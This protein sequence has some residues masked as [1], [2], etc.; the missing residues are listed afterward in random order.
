MISMT[1]MLLTPQYV[2]AQGAPQREASP[3]QNPQK[4]KL[5]LA[6]HMRGLEMLY[7]NNTISTRENFC[8][9]T[10]DSALNNLTIRELSTLATGKGEPVDDKKMKIKVQ[11][12]C[13]HYIIKENEYERCYT[14]PRFVTMMRTEQG[15]R[16]MCTC[17]GDKISVFVKD[18]GEDLMAYAV[19]RFPN[20]RSI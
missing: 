1:L 3:D 15:F 8:G 11:A 19:E 9:C 12:K 4:V 18:Y 17:M 2:L 20:R 13:L 16:D 5:V 6:Y 10:A 7:T 14:N